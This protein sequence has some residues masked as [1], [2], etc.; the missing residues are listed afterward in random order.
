LKRSLVFGIICLFLGSGFVPMIIPEV[1]A[2]LTTGLVGYWNFDE[3]SGNIIQV[4]ISP[5]YR[6]FYSYSIR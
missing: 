6:I 4:L 1:K 2:D 5:G 3:G